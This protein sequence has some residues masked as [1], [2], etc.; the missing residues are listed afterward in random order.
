MI[1][2]K[3]KMLAALAAPLLLLAACGDDTSSNGAS[4]SLPTE[5][6]PEPPDT[7]LA[8]PP[9]TVPTTPE[10]EHPT[11]PDDVVVKISYEGGF[12]PIEYAFRNLPALL[13]SG[14][15]R[16][17]Q[18]GPMIEIY[19]G[20]LLTPVN[21]STA[22]EAGIQD[23]LTLADEHGLLADVEYT[24]PTNIADAATT[25][26]VI[27]ADGNTYRHEAYAL[28]IGDETDLARASLAEFVQ[29][30][31]GDWLYG[32]PEV[33]GEQPFSPETYLILAM[34]APQDTGDIPPTLVDWP[35]DASVRLADAR[36]C[37]AVPA[38]EVGELF[39]NATQL[40]YFVDAG[41]TYQVSVKPQLPG[42]A[43]PTV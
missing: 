28:G 19:P 40:T 2:S 34:D 26:V 27:S 20:P 12:V 17:F 25:V 14:D 41:V 35:A 30:A 8:V 22:S 13:V 29:L 24:N 21:V 32:N 9:T 6:I 38:S 23:L 15:G 3:F 11:G 10:Y 5:T 42:D 31:T 7:T 1:G 16:S 37:A 4:T 36:N 18:P 43:C 39:A 33:G